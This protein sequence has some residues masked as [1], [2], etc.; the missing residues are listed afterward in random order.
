VSRFIHGQALHIAYQHI[1]D[2]ARQVDHYRFA[3]P[4]RQLA[5][6]SAAGAQSMAARPKAAITAMSNAVRISDMF[7]ISIPSSAF[8]SPP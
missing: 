1:F 4:K 2:V 8:P 3:D 5:R 7:P 6:G